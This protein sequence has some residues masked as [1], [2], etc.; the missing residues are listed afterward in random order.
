MGAVGDPRR[1]TQIERP[2]GLDHCSVADDDGVCV[3]PL[4][5]AAEVAAK[6]DARTAEEEAKRVRYQ[7]SELSLDINQM[8]QKLKDKGL[9]Y[10]AQKDL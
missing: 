9:I 3:V 8:R 7:N 4:A 1:A 2:G 6:A 5:R 10:V